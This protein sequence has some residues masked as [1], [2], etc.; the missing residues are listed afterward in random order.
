MNSIEFRK[1]ILNDWILQYPQLSPYS[2][3]ILCMTCDIIVIGLRLLR[4]PNGAGYRPMFELYPLWGVDVKS[5]FEY[6]SLY[7]PI[8]DKR[9]SVLNIRYP[10]HKYHFDEVIECV[11]K[12]IGRF[13]NSDVS[14]NELIKY[15]DYRDKIDTLFQAN[16]SFRIPLMELELYLAKYSNNRILLDSIMNNIDKKTKKWHPDHF[17]IS[18]ELWKKDLFERVDYWDKVLCCIQ[19]NLNNPKIAKLNK[20]H[21]IF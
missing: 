19:N 6:P 9:D 15:I 17:N 11:Y 3:T 12:Q 14:V 4:L 7:C 18:I 21:L 8:V 13:L 16:N 10:L 1:E 5:I 20:A 2:S